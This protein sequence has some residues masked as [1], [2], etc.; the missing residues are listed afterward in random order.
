MNRRQKIIVSVVG[1]FIVLLALV[2][3]TYGY[4]LT[5]IQGNTNTT[6]ISVTTA[7]LALVYDGDNG[8]IIGANEVIEPNKTFTT[9][10]FTVENKGNT[11]INAYAVILQDVSITDVTT[12]EIK[13][14]LS[15]REGKE[16]DFDL[17]IKC[18][19]GSEEIVVYNAELPE[20][21][22]ILVKNSID[23]GEIHTY[24][25]T[26]TYVETNDDQSDDMNKRI[27][28]KFNIIDTNDTAIIEGKVT[29]TTKTQ[30]YVQ[31]N[32]TKRVSFIDSNGNYKILGLEAG[33][34]TLKL[35][36]IAD[37][38]CSNPVLTK[39]ILIK[40][41]SVANGNNS[42]GEI[43][44]SG[45]H[46]IAA[47]DINKD[48]NTIIVK[49]DIKF[50]NPYSEGTLA[51]SIIDNAM[52]EK[53]GT[54]LVAFP[55]TEIGTASSINY[56]DA[57]DSYELYPAGVGGYASSNASDPFYCYHYD[58]GMMGDDASVC[59][60]VIKN[61]T[62]CSQMKGKYV[63]NAYDIYNGAGGNSN[64][65]YIDECIDGKP[66]ILKPQRE[67][68]L[69]STEDDY[70]TSYYYRGDVID[71]Y[72]NF[73]G[74]CWRI[75][76][77]QGDGSIKL[78]LENRESTCTA[79]T[80]SGSSTDIADYNKNGYY[81]VINPYIYL[82]MNRENN[83]GYQIVDGKYKA[84]LS[85]PYDPDF[86]FQNMP[87]AL[88]AGLSLDQS[89]LKSG[90]WC[91]G[92]VT[93][94]TSNSYDYL[95]KTRFSNKNYSFKCDGSKPSELSYVGILTADEMVFAGLSETS[96]MYYNYLAYGKQMT[97]LTLSN[98]N[99]SRDYAY[100]VNNKGKITTASVNSELFY[101]IPSV[102]LK[103]GITVTSG[104]GSLMNPY[105]IG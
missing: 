61:V 72:V 85:N 60:G 42:T 58:Q 49:E 28:G 71:N 26:L 105:V 55:P 90:D 56:N 6:S 34:H 83:Y 54:S 21:N 19:D 18:N 78:V 63:Y 70:A 22:A 7:D 92:N 51:Y 57:A 32:S 14:L 12:G 79:N 86:Q 13:P 103:D 40:T 47:I 67:R 102:I 77:I 46:N 91:F 43:T 41:G 93:K 104:D 33:Q 4:F 53:N 17:V 94:S 44:I 11:T 96:D 87:Q 73:A 45:G 8:S 30:Y 65:I 95:S 36:N 75:V 88:Q 97:A 99:G 2:G 66:A 68:V 89:K 31:T 38:T 74:S 24:S 50:T 81:S 80:V 1:I 62:S 100:L 27:T 16:N 84:S 29:N 101:V 59:D 52:T 15:T 5:R 20:Q 82:G 76:R 39:N 98:F 35:C 10:T 25:A 37:T 64:G 3:I 48:S 23:P 9:K 69:A